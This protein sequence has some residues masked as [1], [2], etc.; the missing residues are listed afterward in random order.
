MWL[1][2]PSSELDS[3]PADADLKSDLKSL[4][5]DTPLSTGNASVDS[6][7][8]YLRDFLANRSVLLESGR[9]PVTNDGSGRTLLESSAKS[10]E[11]QTNQTGN[12]T[13]SSSSRTF[14]DSSSIPIATLTDG[15]WM[16]SQMTLL[17][18]WEPFSGTWPGSGSMRNGVV[19]ERPMSAPVMAE[20]ESSFWPTAKAITGGAEQWQTPGTDSFRSRGGDRADEM[21]LDQEARFWQTPQARERWSIAEYGNARPLNEQVINWA[22]PLTGQTALWG[23][24][25]AHGRSYSARDV[26]HGIQLANQTETWESSPTVQPI[27]DGKACWCRVPGCVLRGHK[28]KLNPIFV[29]WMMGWPHWWLLTEPVPLGHSGMASYLS[30]QRT[31]LFYLLGG[32]V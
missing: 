28:R 16:S 15:R 12:K 1:L 18:E 7:V 14:P 32:R 20:R 13:P 17:G 24:P 3:A 9:E 23:T 30:K 31:A 19:F 22:T 10:S 11:P 25:N 6:F 29:L 27:Q 21:G 2:I 5:P 4:F 26:H 8:S